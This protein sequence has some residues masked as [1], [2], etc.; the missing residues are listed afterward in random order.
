MKRAVLLLL[1]A[2]LTLVLAGCQGSGVGQYPMEISDIADTADFPL[3]AA[4]FERY[5]ILRYEPG[6][7]D[8]SVGYNMSTPEAQ[9]VSTIYMSDTSVF[10]EMLEESNPV[11]ALFS[12]AKAYIE[13]YHAGARLLGEDS[14][15]LEKNGHQYNA[16]R[17]FFRYDEDFMSKQQPVY[18]V[19]MIWRNGDDFIKLRSTMPFTQR[20][21]WET[22]NINLLDAVNWTKPP[23]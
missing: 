20:T 9:I 17:A 16:L 10:P 3:R 7:A 22:N 5:R 14:M 8:I 13:D 6:D 18:S 4:G 19:L 12:A 15:V 1:C 11:A 21:L 23:S 2:G